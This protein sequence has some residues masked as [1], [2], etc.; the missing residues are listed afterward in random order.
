MTNLRTVHHMCLKLKHAYLS[1][2]PRVY[3]KDTPTMRGITSILHKEGFL[4]SVQPGDARAPF[5]D[6]ISMQSPLMN[7]Q[8]KRLEMLHQMHQRLVTLHAENKST[9]TAAD[10]TVCVVPP[11]TALHAPSEIVSVEDYLLVTPIE[12]RRLWLSLRYDSY[13][14]PALTHMR[15][16]STPSRKVTFNPQDPLHMIQV[17]GW[18]YKPENGVGNGVAVVENETHGFLTLEEAIRRK[19]PAQLICL[20]Q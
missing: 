15:L 9:F 2:R 7:S 13:L 12:D 17:K 4:V 20:A 19:L 18:H 3:L 6:L 5:V 11:V 8:Q 10:G 14:R 16:L 1:Q